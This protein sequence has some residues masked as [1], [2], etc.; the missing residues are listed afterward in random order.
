MIH[1]CSCLK[2]IVKVW[3][4]LFIV[5]VQ[6]SLRSEPVLRETESRLH[7][8]VLVGVDSVFQDLRSRIDVGKTKTN[9]KNVAWKFL[10][11]FK[12]FLMSF[13][14]EFFF[15][16]T[17]AIKV[18]RAKVMEK[19]IVNHTISFNFLLK[20]YKIFNLSLTFEITLFLIELKYCR[21][22][23]SFNKNET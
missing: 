19:L 7:R 8:L 20:S 13:L 9:S 14:W 5:Y 3:R 6:A 21:Y 11:L 23:L 16:H 4:F 15:F 22:I 10:G 17:I 2:L 1:L 18:T 12:W